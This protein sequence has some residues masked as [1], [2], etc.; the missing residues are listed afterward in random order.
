M[1]QVKP[2]PEKRF[3]TEGDSGSMWYACSG[4]RFIPIGIHRGIGFGNQICGEERDYVA[5][6]T[7]LYLNLNSLVDF[8]NDLLVI[9]TESEIIVC[10]KRDCNHGRR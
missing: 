9:E 10:E 1:L 6:A 4:H 2:L 8:F 7:P 5:F 3:L